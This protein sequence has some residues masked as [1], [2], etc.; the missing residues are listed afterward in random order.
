MSQLSEN[1]PSIANSTLNRVH[2]IQC[3]DQGDLRDPKLCWKTQP[4]RVSLPFFLPTIGYTWWKLLQ[5]L[6]LR[7]CVSEHISTLIPDI[8]QILNCTKPSFTLHFF[9]A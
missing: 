5:I 7:A 3:H 6:V 1:R 4:F 2:M 8:F 9:P